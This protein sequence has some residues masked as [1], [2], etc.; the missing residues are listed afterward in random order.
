M[1][2]AMKHVDLLSK[3][4]PADGWFAVLGIKRVND[5]AKRQQHLVATREEVDDL[6]ARLVRNKW[7]VFYGV[8]KYASNANRT[9]ENVQALRAF[10][11]DIDCG[12]SKA[13]VNEKTGRPDG[14]IDQAAG[15][16]ALKQFCTKVGLP[17][18]LLVNSGRGVHAYW[19]LTRD[20]SR[21]EWEPVGRRLAELC[22]THNFYV[23]ASV[24]EVAR[25]L[26]IPGTY[27]FK[28]DPA[29]EV[30]VIADADPVDYD[31][32]R[33][34]LGV[35]E[36]Q[37]LVVPE[38]RKS[39]LSQKLQDNNISR[40]SK[41]LRRSAKGDG[42]QQ[43]VAA[44]KERDTLSEV[45]W[46]DALSIAKFCV[47]RDTAIQKMSHGHPD[48]D[49]MRT[50]DKI[51]HITGPHNCATFDRNNPGGCYGCPYY[52]KIKN[53]IVL[54]KEVA[55]AETEDGVYIVP[56]D[57]EEDTPLDMRIPEYPF[58]FVRGKKGG[59]YLK[60]DDDEK[61]PDLV[62]E[63]DLYLV[64]TMTDPKEGDV[65]VM[66]LH[67]PKEGVREFIL[68]QKQAVGDPG[69]LRK[70]LASKG[71]AA[72]EKQFKSLVLFVVMS[73]KAIQHKRKAEL[74]RMQ[75]G[76][77]DNNSKFIVGDREVTAD[78][79]YHSPPSSAT[80][81]LAERMVTAGSYE[82]WQ[83]VFNLYG[84][85]GLE[86][87]A[88]AALTA[89]G[90]PLFKFT[91]QSGAILNVIHPNSGT[92]KTTILHMCNSVWGH[93]KDLCGIKGDTANAKTQ[94]LGVFNNL[95]FCV[96][97][98]TNM[99]PAQLSEMAYNMSQGR[100][101]HRMKASSNELRMNNTTWQTISLCSSNSSFYEKMGILKN[102]PDGEMM[103]LLEY[104]IDYHSAIPTDYAKEMFDHQ[105]LENYG[106]AGTIY[107][108]WVLNNL[109]EVKNTLKVVQTKIDRELKLTQRERFW[110]AEVAA[111]LTG[112]MIARRLKIINWDMKRI[113]EWATGI[114]QETRKDVQPPPTSAASILGDYLNR[115]IHNI[116]VVN[117]AVDQRSNM[118]T[119]PEMEPKGPLH[120]RFEPDTKRLFVDYKHMREDCAR[121]QIN[122]KQFL[123]DMKKL[124]A[125]I[126]T[127]TKRL[128]KGM[129]VSTLPVYA[130]EFDTTVSDFLDM[131]TFIPEKE[132]A[133]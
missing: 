61:T 45:R 103:R 70:V 57:G 60:P 132:D 129:K 86:P 47:D 24:F 111:N 88:F 28:D 15:I 64:K 101:K 72:T 109:E 73:L 63:H 131:G 128:S 56:E 77:A 78:G 123:A 44:Y 55:E 126:D 97:E 29:V 35:K 105:L 49:P 54:G 32:F 4:Q 66:R 99:T 59:I 67:L 46:F 17:R 81:E 37:D 33:K 31:E 12:P 13:A 8:A 107:I 41:I 39:N 69:E 80:R 98:I 90:A 34:A 79:I 119:L 68:T 26:R 76:W 113:Y 51:K 22:V 121:S 21:Q 5:E 104:K 110:S 48:Y 42:C 133:D 27:N 91:G 124:G 53:P 89:F 130:I 94:H 82:K 96:D 20:I 43:L 62:Y 2:Y 87:H 52:G 108:Q 92:G 1:D 118:A 115:H 7:N 58:P 71:V 40:F 6:A 127:S 120:I 11:V 9:K 100:G 19:P 36:V 18:P 3:V 125:Y 14:Y 25:I 85:E 16:A 10:W 65:L 106:H 83:E 114:I 75:F 93:P 23:D 50:L 102:S 74:M 122:F 117:D 95:P 84:R 112:G 38:R 116:L 30:T